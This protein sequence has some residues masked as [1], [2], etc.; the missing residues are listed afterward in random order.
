[1]WLLLKFLITALTEVFNILTWLGEIGRVFVKIVH[2]TPSL[3]EGVVKEPSYL[4]KPARSLGKKVDAIRGVST[5]TATPFGFVSIWGNSSRKGSKYSSS[6]G[7]IYKN[8]NCYIRVKKYNTLF[9][10]YFSGVQVK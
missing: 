10:K 8:S 4:K 5:L 6:S 9:S 2:I 1:M 3:Q 7:E